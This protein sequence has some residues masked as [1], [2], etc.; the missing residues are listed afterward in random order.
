VNKGSGSGLRKWQFPFGPLSESLAPEASTLYFEAE[1]EWLVGRELTPQHGRPTVA[2][3]EAERRLYLR[4][5]DA[6]EVTE[7]GQIILRP[8]WREQ[9]LRFAN[10][11]APPRGRES[12]DE[13]RAPICTF[14]E[15][16]LVM[17]W[18][19]RLKECLLDVERHES[20]HPA[21]VA[22][23][24][25]SALQYLSL[26]GRLIDYEA[27][28]RE[29][30][31]VPHEPE[32]LPIET[33]EAIATNFL[34]LER[35]A[36]GNEES[37][38]WQYAASALAWV[39]FKKGRGATPFCAATHLSR[40]VVRFNSG[41]LFTTPLS[42][43][44]FGFWEDLGGVRHRCCPKCGGWFTTRR[45]TKLYCSPE[46]QNAAKVSRYRTGEP[47]PAPWPKRQPRSTK[48]RPGSSKAVRAKRRPAGPH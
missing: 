35:Q 44:W 30:K 21:V 31:S 38:G 45:E 41:F 7:E 33:A 15:E 28:L 34:G 4:L 47:A 11:Y 26:P 25:L 8:D 13:T 10:L 43:I 24:Q 1:G 2:E 32:S 46:C 12:V 48:A 20:P 18:A 19:L 5:V 29:A 3:I 17:A 6:T 9:A 36:G 16:A 39:T 40:R 37:W 27:R 23:V 22:A 14:A 42:R